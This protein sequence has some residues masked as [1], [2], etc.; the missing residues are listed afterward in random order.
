MTTMQTLPLQLGLYRQIADL[1]EQMVA[2]ARENDWD[3]LVELERSVAALRD[4]LQRMGDEILDSDSTADKRRLI[5]KI[6]ADDAE[7]RRHTEPWVEHVRRF[8][9]AGAKQRRVESAYGLS[10]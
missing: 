4:Q 1:S 5:Q 8:L 3:T 9:G 2:A 7:V 6:L 10:T